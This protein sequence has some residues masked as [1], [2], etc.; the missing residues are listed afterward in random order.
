MKVL[1]ALGL[2][3]VACA[4]INIWAAVVLHGAAN[5]FAAVFNAVVAGWCFGLAWMTRD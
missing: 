4:A 3:N 2:I 5:Q 1:I